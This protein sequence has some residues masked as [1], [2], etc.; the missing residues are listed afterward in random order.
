MSLS[1]EVAIEVE[2]LQATY[3]DAVRLVDSNDVASLST[4][5]LCIQALVLPHGGWEEGGESGAAAS[6]IWEGSPPP[7]D[8]YVAGV[9]E[10]A[11]PQVGVGCGTMQS[12]GPT[13]QQVTAPEAVRA[14]LRVQP[15]GHT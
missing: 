6:D 4:G 15:A 13:K 10:L 5:L 7:A 3:A 2:A 11:V 14:C 9:L 8:C 12:A 1:D